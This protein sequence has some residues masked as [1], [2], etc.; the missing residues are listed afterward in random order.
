MA[1]EKAPPT[2]QRVAQNTA[3]EINEDIR[4]RT[5]RNIEYFSAR[6][7]EIEHRLEELERE[8]DVERVLETNAA[9]F[10]LAGLTLGM[11]ISRKWLAL[12]MVVAGFLLQH[13]VQGWCPPM[14]LFRRLGVR[15]IGE[16]DQERYALKALRGD[17][18]G[19]EKGASSESKPRKT[20]AR[21]RTRKAAKAAK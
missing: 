4:R 6:L 17:F 9:A 12:P 14:A 18:A 5:M 10:S 8:W 16:I 7:D 2:R 11:T 15:T 13:A 19:L 20:P 21:K 3:D 1:Q